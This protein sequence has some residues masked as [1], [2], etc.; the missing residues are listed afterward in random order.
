MALVVAA[1]VFSGCL[2]RSRPSMVG[3]VHDGRAHLGTAGASTRFRLAYEPHEGANLFR[4]TAKKTTTITIGSSPPTTTTST[5]TALARIRSL[6]KRDGLLRYD[7]ELLEGTETDEAGKTTPLKLYPGLRRVYGN[8]PGTGA[9]GEMQWANPPA[10]MTQAQLDA[11]SDDLYFPP[12]VILPDMDV[13]AGATWSY[14][15][16]MT[17]ANLMTVRDVDQT[18]SVRSITAAGAELLVV[19]YSKLADRKEGPYEL[20]N[21]RETKN[22]TAWVQG[23]RLPERVSLTETRLYDLV[24][25]TNGTRT[26]G[27]MKVDFTTAQEAVYRK[28]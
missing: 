17:G 21:G 28:K 23:G 15:G 10:G 20:T 11:E 26:T 27:T 6:G 12:E 13:G 9:W 16:E 7:S 4:T 3:P 22:M 19:I 25:T 24:A 1:F 8:Q 5:M 14:S 18:T 2:P